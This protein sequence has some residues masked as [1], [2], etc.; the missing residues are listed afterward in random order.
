MELLD[1]VRSTGAEIKRA[2]NEEY[3]CRC[4]LHHDTRPSMYVNP[5]KGKWICF[6]CGR[7]GD[8]I[9]LVM[10]YEGISFLEALARVG[11]GDS[12]ERIAPAARQDALT[13][14]IR[15]R[16]TEAAHRYERF[17]DQNSQAWEY[18]TWE[19]GLDPLTILRNHLGY[20]PSQPNT[21]DA[22]LSH[23]DA[24]PPLGDGVKPTLAGHITIPEFN[25]EFCTYL[26]GRRLVPGEP[27]YMGLPGLPKPLYGSWRFRNE[28]ILYLVEG[29]FDWLTLLQWGL[30]AVSSLGC[31]L[32]PSQAAHLSNKRVVLAQDA[33]LAG[34]L[35]AEQIARTLPNSTR[36]RP[37]EP[38]KD[39]NDALVG[40]WKREDFLAYERDQLVIA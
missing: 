33:D 25:D 20:C 32:S 18:L 13:G 11:A 30:P 8:L 15:T 31:H 5:T 19:R 7:Y 10:Y 9:S 28:Q 37:P 14:E 3:R 16:L 40:G 35:A 4:I 38:F 21:P 2:G 1:Y 26:Q 6:G 23:L 39:W 29:P 34:D 22:R 17:L 27:R 36:L 12:P 24:Q